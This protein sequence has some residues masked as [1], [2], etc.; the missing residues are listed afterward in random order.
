MLI[1]TPASLSSKDQATKHTIEN[2]Q[3]P[4]NGFIIFPEETLLLDLY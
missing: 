3:K 1:L 4:T 2:K